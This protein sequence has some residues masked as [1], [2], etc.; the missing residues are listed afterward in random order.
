VPYHGVIGAAEARA[1]QVSLRLRD[2]RKLPPMSIAEALARIGR[3]VHA[4]SI[5]L[6][7]AA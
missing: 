4:R 5:E 7:D 1:D 6:W 2:G 3:Q